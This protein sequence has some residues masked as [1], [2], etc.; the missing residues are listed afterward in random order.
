MSE[1]AEEFDLSTLKPEPKIDTT[2][3]ISADR[4]KQMADL[5]HFGS[6]GPSSLRFS[7]QTKGKP[8]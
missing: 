5:A 3:F 1:A 4:Q 2:L 7:S 8:H 6:R